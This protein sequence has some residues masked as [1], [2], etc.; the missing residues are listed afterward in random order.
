LPER[1]V[2]R[3]EGVLRGLEESRESTVDG[4]KST[5][6]SGIASREAA[7]QSPTS[8]AS[9]SQFTIRSSKLVARESNAV[10]DA[11]I[12]TWREVL[13]QIADVDIANMTPVQALNLLNE[14]QI[15]IKS[16]SQVVE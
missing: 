10:Y 16:G 3:A 15:K 7:K 4:Q 6:Y 1:V 8:E 9:N 12:E 5:V 2:V 11:R 14:M 13:R